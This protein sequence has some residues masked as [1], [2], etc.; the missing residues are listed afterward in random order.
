MAD[1]ENLVQT[2][3]IIGAGTMGHGIAQTA[4][5]AGI[6]VILRDVDEAALERGL[7][8]VTKGLG[9]LVDRDR[10]SAEDRDA[11]LGRLTTTTDLQALADVDAVIEA[12]SERLELK[13]AIF[14]EID[15][16]C[17][18]A[19]FLASNTSSIPIQQIAVSLADDRKSRAVGLHYFNPAQVM[20]LVE[21]VRP[22]TASDEAV[23]AAQAFVRETGKTPISAQDTPAF[24]VNRLFV[25]MALD[26]LRMWESGVAT[27]EDIDE[28]MKLGLGHNMGPLATSDLV[29]LDVMLDVSESMFEELRDP[30]VAPPT[31]LRRLV[32]AGRLGRKSGHGVFDYS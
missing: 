10:L 26:A 23:A 15:A 28:G 27:A 1:Q 24:I 3:G 29:G 12:A 6:A 5:L 2:L 9:R 13:R 25:P 4:I 32:A 7:A 18:K 21:V 22:L 30:H 20:P 14:A 11:A 19:I 17:E 31:I 8:G 16:V